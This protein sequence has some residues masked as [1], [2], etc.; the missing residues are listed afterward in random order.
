MTTNLSHSILTY[1]LVSDA[2]Q[3]VTIHH[4][5]D[6]YIFIMMTGMILLSI[7]CYF[8]LKVR[9]MDVAEEKTRLII[10]YLMHHYN[11]TRY[12]F[13]ERKDD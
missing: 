11:K 8:R 7:A 3:N 9:A 6:P 10:N 13:P 4:E 2:D 1:Y 12:N 5:C